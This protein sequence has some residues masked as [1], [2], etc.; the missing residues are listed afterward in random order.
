MSENE[1]HHCV[2]VLRMKRGDKVQFI[3]GK[4]GF[5]E[6]MIDYEDPMACR[7]RVH[8]KKPGYEK[9]PWFLHIA[10]AP[11]KNADRFEW[12][13][14]KATEIGVDR[15]TPLVCDHSERR[16]IRK[17]RLERV[18]LSAVKQ[19]VKAWLPQLD[20]LT[21]YKEFIQGDYNNMQKFI[22]HCR[23]GERKD[24][25]NLC[26]QADPSLVLIGPEGDFSEKEIELASKMNFIP[27]SL[28][29]SRLR[30]ETA[31]VVTAQIL[32]DLHIMN[33]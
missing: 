24:L 13:L 22:A 23:E 6:G 31:G 2:K 5:Y 11:T 10:I 9:R 21:D 7:V 29:N 25:I 15:I 16:R 19:S 12:F 4:G 18:I 3:D 27:V 8:E 20:D 17:D 1:S 14:E 33:K 30:T 26:N 32:S 28:G